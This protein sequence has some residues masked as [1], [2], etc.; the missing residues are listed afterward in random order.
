MFLMLCLILVFS[1]IPSLLCF[2]NS[3][4]EETSWQTTEAPTEAQQLVFFCFR[5]TS[6]VLF[7]STNSYQS[8]KFIPSQRSLQTASTN[9]GTERETG[10]H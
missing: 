10:I 2:W 6:E 9:V 3:T 8:L 7:H 5:C 1:T 4:I